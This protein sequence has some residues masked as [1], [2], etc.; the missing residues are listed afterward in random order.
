[1]PST[2]TPLR[3]PGGKSKLKKYMRQII[4]VNGLE[5]GTYVEP[6]AG[7]AGIAVDLIL[8]G[9]V[10][11]AILNDI[12]PSI[13][14]FWHSV[15]YDTDALCE[16]I[17]YTPVTVNE[18]LKQRE[19]QKNKNEVTL[20]ELGFSTFFLNRTNR[21]GII[22]GGIIGGLRQSGS[23]KLDCRFN[24]DT[25][26]DKIRDISWHRDRFEIHC[27]DAEELLTSSHSW[28][29][30]PRTFL[31]ID[32]PYV[33]KGSKLYGS[34]Y[35]KENHERIAALIREL[36][37]PWLV[38]YDNVPLVENMY[39][40]YKQMKY[41]VNYTAQRKYAG[42]EIMIFSNGL[43]IPVPGRMLKVI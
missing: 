42:S 21:S 3:Y 32:P 18:W 35:R 29:L 19:V 33:G 10:S 2:M 25:L 12:D 11:K 39:A 34:F 36:A 1:M 5:G 6:Y 14:A 40:D 41:S 20:L 17:R 27:K 9:T 16:Q 26:I 43:A 7:G 24:K 4:A 37:V 30:S 23:Y 13:F 15:L 31:F 38:T 22:E 8:S 28:L